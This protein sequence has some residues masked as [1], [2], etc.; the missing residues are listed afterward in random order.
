M[1]DVVPVTIGREI[2]ECGF[3]EA[4]LQDYI[5]D[6]PSCLAACFRVDGLEGVM[7]ERSQEGGGRLDLLLKD[8]DD[9]TMYEVEVTLDETNADHIIRTIEYWDRERRRWPMYAGAQ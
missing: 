6:N 3:D 1:A 9:E 7:K 5:W 8:P 2:R 4:W